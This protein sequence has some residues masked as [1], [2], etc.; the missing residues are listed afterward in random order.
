MPFAWGHVDLEIKIGHTDRVG[1][2]CA[3]YPVDSHSLIS[4]RV[5][6]MSLQICA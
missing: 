1:V 4:D 6:P 2:R 3:D 5:M